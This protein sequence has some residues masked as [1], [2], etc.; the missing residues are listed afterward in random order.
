MSIIKGYQLSFVVIILTN[1]L[2]IDQMSTIIIN[3]VI[4]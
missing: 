2:N 4:L 3:L 1:L